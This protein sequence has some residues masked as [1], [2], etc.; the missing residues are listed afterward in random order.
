M[1]SNRRLVVAGNWK[2]YGSRQRIEDFSLALVGRDLS[3]GPDVV[4]FP[5]AVYL[6][7]CV[8]RMAGVGV[9]LGC[10]DLHPQPEGAHTGDV[11]APMILDLGARWALAGHSERRRDHAETD[12]Q[13]AA[14]FEAAANAGLT[15]IYCIGESLEERESGQAEAVVARQL[16][17]LIDRIGCQALCAGALAY[18]PVWAIG[19]G[20]TATPAQAEAM[21]AM[22]RALLCEQD[23]ATAER[24]R[25]LY[26][27]SV[28]AEN[29]ASLFSQPNVDGG[30]V[31]GA[32]LEA[33]SFLAIIDAARL[34]ATEVA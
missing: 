7:E 10:Q 18:E 30:L 8:T 17:A 24:V 14:K 23:A 27:G 3:A 16:R 6:A 1:Q 31:G 12:Q 15:P 29:A 19:T 26:G 5:P 32:S 21:H 28:N 33:A 22:I 9:A 4:I 25:V 13:A 2:M 11:S 20:V 34:A